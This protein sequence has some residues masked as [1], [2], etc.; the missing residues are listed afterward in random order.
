MFNECKLRNCIY[1]LVDITMDDP[2]VITFLLNYGTG[3][4]LT[5]LKTLP[6]T[7]R[8]IWMKL[9]G[10]RAFAMDIAIEKL[11]R[12]AIDYGL[13]SRKCDQAAEALMCIP[14][15]H[16]Q[17]KLLGDLRAVRLLTFLAGYIILR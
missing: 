1:Y 16:T 15:V 10:L 5:Y 2:G 3:F 13:G 14:S 7:Q 17:P 6:T 12:I 9:G 11:T 4:L 8:N